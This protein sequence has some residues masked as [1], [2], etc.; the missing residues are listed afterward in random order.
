MENKPRHQENRNPR[1]LSGV[2][3]RVAAYFEAS[4][5]CHDCMVCRIHE[6]IYVHVCKTQHDIRVTLCANQWQL[7]RIHSTNV[8][9]C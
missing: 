2:R 4:V 5:W 7:F 8:V 9:S 6:H 1:D 3:L